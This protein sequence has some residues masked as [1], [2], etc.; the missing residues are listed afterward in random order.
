MNTELT[1]L[2]FTILLGILQLMLA[3]SAA[4]KQRGLKWNL[5]SRGGSPP[6]LTDAAGRLDRA[7]QNFKETFP[8]FLAAVVLVISTGRSGEVSAISAW[9]YLLARAAYL[10]IYAFDYT[11]VRSLVWGCSVLAILGVLAQLFI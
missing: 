4:T 10:P 5:S 9:V 2:L 1:A 8:M 6:P 3:T 7:F 11:I